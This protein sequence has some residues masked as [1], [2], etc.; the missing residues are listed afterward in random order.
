MS[1]FDTLWNNDVMNDLYAAGLN[2]DKLPLTYNEN[3]T[4]SI[5]VKTPH[6]PAKRVEVNDDIF[7]GT[8]MAPLQCVVH[9]D[10]LGQQAKL[11]PECL[12]KYR[13]VVPTPP[14]SKLMISL[15][16]LLAI[17]P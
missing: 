11:H 7:Q 10:E 15:Q 13:G 3:K 4:A 17:Q 5:S 9:L 8:V 1:C 2:N 12:Y 14:Y 6:G 16:S